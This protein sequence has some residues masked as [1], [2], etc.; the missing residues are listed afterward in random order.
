MATALTNGTLTVK[1]LGI[2]PAGSRLAKS[3]HELR[4]AMVSQFESFY[5]TGVIL[6]RIRVEREFEDAGFT[7]FDKY[8]DDRMPQGIKRA[9][10]WRVMSAMKIRPL[11]PSLDSPFGESATWTEATIRPMTHKRFTDKDVKKLANKIAKL[12]AAGEPLTAALV[13]KICDDASGVTR[14]KSEKKTRDLASAKTAAEA[15]RHIEY[16]VKQ[17]QSSL[18]NVSGEFWLDAEADDKG[19]VKDLISALSSLASFLRG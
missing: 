1:K 6:E 16:D 17:W 18:E 2:I 9:H 10:A 13:K 14:K 11:L 5:A 4:E 12:V 3:E 8:M 15:L 7:S 19:C